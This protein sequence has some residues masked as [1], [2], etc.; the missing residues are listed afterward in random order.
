MTAKYDTT[1][2]HPGAILTAELKE[3]GLTPD[4]FDVALALPTG[5]TAEIRRSAAASRPNWLCVSDATS[6][7]L[8]DSG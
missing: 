6:A 3:L 8:R 2:A 1:P 7:P 5:A 4:E